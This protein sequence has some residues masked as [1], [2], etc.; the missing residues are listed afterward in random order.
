MHIGT[1]G[2]NSMAMR[3][4]NSMA[5]RIDM[6]WLEPK[7]RARRSLPAYLSSTDLYSFCGT[8]ISTPG[9]TEGGFGGVYTGILSGTN[10]V[11]AV[12]RVSQGFKQG[13]REYVSEFTITSQLRHHNLVQLLG[14]CHESTSAPVYLHDELDNCIVHRNVWTS[15]VILYSNLNAK[16]GDFGLPKIVKHYG[17]SSHTTLPA[18]NLGYLAPQCVVV[19]KTSPESDFLALGELLDSAIRR[20]GGNLNEEE[21]Q[22]LMVVGLLCCE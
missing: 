8:I 1:R 7:P 6:N 18:G 21:M 10:E 11:V 20:L 15:N 3:G 2:W 4:W 19:G 5:E 13:K 16:L 9:K 22:R 12:K 14:W 17:P